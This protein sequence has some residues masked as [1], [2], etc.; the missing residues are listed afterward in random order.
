MGDRYPVLQGDP[1]PSV[2]GHRTQR[3]GPLT[4]RERGRLIRPGVTGGS[5]RTPALEGV[6]QKPNRYPS[7]RGDQMMGAPSVILVG[8]MR[9]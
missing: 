1:L 4:Q 5:P 7:V 6:H 8:R 9:P 3:Y 2:R